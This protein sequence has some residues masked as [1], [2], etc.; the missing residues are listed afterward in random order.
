MEKDGKG[1]VGGA[2]FLV[3]LMSWMALGTQFIK[4]PIYKVIYLF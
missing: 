3:I 1:G 4:G 2:P